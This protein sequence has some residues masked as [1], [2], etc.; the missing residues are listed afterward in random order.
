MASADVHS[1]AV[2]LLFVGSLFIV[3]P[4]VCRGPALGPCFLIHFLV[5]FLSFAIILM[6]KRELDALL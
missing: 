6:G 4:I 1:K 3:A 2:D 5:F